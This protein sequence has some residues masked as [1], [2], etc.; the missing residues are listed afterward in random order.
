MGKGDPLLM[1]MRPI[2]PPTNKVGAQD[3]GA[4]KITRVLELGPFKAPM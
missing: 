4:Q 1:G 3:L 2:F